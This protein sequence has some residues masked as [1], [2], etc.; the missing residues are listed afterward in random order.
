MKVYQENSLYKESYNILKEKDK[1][2]DLLINLLIVAGF[3]I[4]IFIIIIIYILTK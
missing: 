1:L 3:I 2:I 4:F